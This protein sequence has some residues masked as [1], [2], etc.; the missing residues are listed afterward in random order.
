MVRSIL[1]LPF[2]S[3]LESLGEPL[4]G[5]ID[6]SYGVR[7]NRTISNTELTAFHDDGDLIS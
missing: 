5:R 4:R 2:L 3:E 1:F 6:V 7:G